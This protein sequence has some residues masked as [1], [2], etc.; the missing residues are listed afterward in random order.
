MQRNDQIEA[1]RF[2]AYEIYNKL[3]KLKD[4]KEQKNSGV[5]HLLNTELDQ[6]QKIQPGTYQILLNILLRELTGLNDT[7][8]LQTVLDRGADLFSANEFGQTALTYA[9]KANCPDAVEFLLIKFAASK[10]QND[11]IYAEALSFLVYHCRDNPN[12]VTIAQKIT[13]H[14]KKYAGEACFS[15]AFLLATEGG[16]GDSAMFILKHSKLLP[17]IIQRAC[18]ILTARL[19]NEPGVWREVLFFALVSRYPKEFS[20]LFKSAANDYS[21]A[22]IITVHFDLIMCFKLYPQFEK[23]EQLHIYERMKTIIQSFLDENQTQH[24]DRF[25]DKKHLTPEDLK[26]AKALA[27]E[28][29]DEKFLQKLTDFEKKQEAKSDAA[30]KGYQNNQLLK[31]PGTGFNLGL[32]I[33]HFITREKPLFRGWF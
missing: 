15:K 20:S 22:S 28:N 12:I 32:G 8:I 33:Q 7:Q 4:E 23:S 16:H 30:S 27:K 18:E 5:Q 3:E 6:A 19:K 21:I 9:V 31:K 14:F 2:K 1:L 25:N 10:K 29:N 24:L 26:Q 13:A 11:H 17:T